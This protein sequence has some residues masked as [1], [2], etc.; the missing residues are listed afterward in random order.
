MKYWIGLA[1]LKQFKKVQR[2]MIDHFT[3]S[4]VTLKTMRIDIR[5]KIKFTPFEKGVNF[6]LYLAQNLSVSNLHKT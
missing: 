6:I 5:N 1:G 3:I 2:Q 4:L